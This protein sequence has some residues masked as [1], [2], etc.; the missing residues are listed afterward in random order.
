VNKGKKVRILLTK[1]Y[2]DDHD[3]G[4]KQIA[5]GLRESGA[6]VIFT[7]FRQPE[8]IVSGVLQEDVDFIGISSMSGGYMYFVP[9]LMKLL[10]EKGLTKTRVI[11]GGIIS[12]D[13]IA[14]LEETGVDKVFGPGTFISDIA[15]HITSTGN[16]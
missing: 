15:N 5:I 7:Q 3:R 12:E 16:N 6:E 9:E 4:I 14:K 2:F 10:K 8:E 13:D 1:S 11:L